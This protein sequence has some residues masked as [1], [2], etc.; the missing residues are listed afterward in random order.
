[1]SANPR[2]TILLID[3]DKEIVLTIGDFLS[4]N[5]YTIVTA[6]NGK[7][8][9]HRLE[10][11]RPDLIILDIN[12]PSMNGLAFLATIQAKPEWGDLPVYVF[13]GRANMEQYFKEVR[14]AGFMAKPCLPD[15]LLK[16]IKNILAQRVQSNAASAKGDQ[17]KLLLIE[18]NGSRYN[19]LAE[20]CAQ[21]GFQVITPLGVGDVVQMAIAEK[22]DGIMMQMFMDVMNGLQIAS[23]LRMIPATRNLPILIYDDTASSLVQ[24]AEEYQGDRLLYIVASA[25]HKELVP[26]M[27]HLVREAGRS[28]SGASPGAPGGS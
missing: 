21:A 19:E 7:E 24:T 9:L 2:P 3:D 1:M 14:V 11:I 18:P 17:V 26:L 6:T 13:T 12:M 28:V 8:A 16:D 4:L 25:R 5:G 27:Q 15:K 10:S 22:P 23:I 20:Q